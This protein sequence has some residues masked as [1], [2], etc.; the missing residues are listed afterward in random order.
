MKNLLVIIL[1][2]TLLGC[3]SAKMEKVKRIDTP[4]EGRALVNF[5][6]PSVF[7]GDGVTFEL[8]DSEH[9]IG[10]LAAGT[11]VQFS[12][13]PGVHIFMVDAKNQPWN[14]VEVS[15]K[16]GETYYIKANLVP[17]Y[18]VILG[19]AEDDDI[20]IP[21][22]NSELKPMAIS[23]DSKPLPASDYE[24]A[25]KKLKRFSE[26]TDGKNRLQKES[27]QP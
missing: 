8:W 17:F 16:E 5:V 26:D 14:Y 21:E 25:Q 10:S 6:R 22:W 24:E 27:G 7:L 1:T 20:R 9:F 3:A 19:V 15:L 13:L 4:D 12:A 23:A 2:F 11:M 18:G